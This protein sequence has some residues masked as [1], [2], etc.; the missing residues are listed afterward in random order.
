MFASDVGKISLVQEPYYCTGRLY[1]G[2][3]LWHDR[4]H[5]EAVGLA[6]DGEQ[7]LVCWLA[8]DG[9]DGAAPD[10]VFLL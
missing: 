10:C 6:D 3:G 4:P 2:D 8:G 9:S 7:Y 1:L 5:Y